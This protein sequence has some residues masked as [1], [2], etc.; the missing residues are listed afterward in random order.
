[1]EKKFSFRL[2]TLLVHRKKI[3]DEKAGEVARVT[4]IRLQAQGALQAVVQERVA[5]IE[6]QAELMRAGQFEIQTLEDFEN[7]RIT[8]EKRAIAKQKELDE[9]FAAEEAARQELVKARQEREILDKL[10]QKQHLEY[11][12]ELDAAEAKFIDELATQAYARKP[13]T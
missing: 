11:L 6:Q 8:L 12:K 4:H 2:Q 3:E 13:R 1:M 5:L 10:R 7:W 9:A